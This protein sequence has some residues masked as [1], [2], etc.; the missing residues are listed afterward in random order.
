MPFSNITA[1]IP[2]INFPTYI[3]S[4][5]PRQFPSRVIVTYPPYLPSLSKILDSA[6]K[7]VIEAYL[8][9]RVALELSPLLGQ[10][11]DAW[12]AVRELQEVLGGLKKGAIPDRAEYCAKV[13]SNVMV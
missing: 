5:S 3:S 13:V 12:K 9:S 2:Q 7:E 6:E 8:I 10:E 1:S 11:T 4:F